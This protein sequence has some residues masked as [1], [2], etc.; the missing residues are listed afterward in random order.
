MTKD[1]QATPNHQMFIITVLYFSHSLARVWEWDPHY[2]V[3]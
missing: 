2:N 1:I 3:D